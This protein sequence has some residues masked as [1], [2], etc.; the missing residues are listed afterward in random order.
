MKTIYSLLAGLLICATTSAQNAPVWASP[1]TGGVVNN[2][3]LEVRLDEGVAKERFGPDYA[4]T[5]A[6]P[7]V[8]PA[9]NL[10]P[11]YLTQSHF[12]SLQEYEDRVYVV[13]GWA[14]Y[15]GPSLVRYAPFL[16]APGDLHVKTTGNDS[17][18]DGSEGA[19]Y[20]TIA[21]ALE[22]NVD[23]TTTHPIWVHE[24]TYAQDHSIVGSNGNTSSGQGRLRIIGVSFSSTVVVSAVPGDRVV[25]TSTAG[26][27]VIDFDATETNS[28]L[29]FRGFTLEPAPGTRY[30]YANNA[31]VDSLTISDCVM[32]DATQGESLRIRHLS[33][34][35]DNVKILRNLI[36]GTVGQ[37]ILLSGINGLNVLGNVIHTNGVDF[38]VRLNSNIV[39]DV[40]V[41]N[42]S[43]DVAIGIE[44][45]SGV[46]SAATYNIIG[47]TIDAA[48]H[49]IDLFG[50][51][52]TADLTLN[53]S[54][55]HIVAANEGITVVEYVDGGVVEFNHVRAGLAGGTGNTGLGLPS[56]SANTGPVSGLTVRYNDVQSQGGHATLFSSTS[57]GYVAHDNIASARDGGDHALVIKGVEHELTRWRLLSG[58]STALYL[59]GFQNGTIQGFDIDCDGAT[60]P[61]FAGV[62]T[63]QGNGVQD[64]EV[65]NNV[66]FKNNQIRATDSPAILLNSSTIGSAVS[67][68]SNVYDISGTATWGSVRDTSISS[69]EDLV[70]AWA[71]YGVSGNDSQSISE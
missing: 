21:K 41:S 66:T 37:D 17:T 34:T 27:G 38:G 31:V 12:D 54:R 16:P 5:L 39:G 32:A 20:L 7:T 9:V 52:A 57:S 71:G 23:N 28:S 26:N 69:L 59:K 18:G 4:L 10:A 35:S 51:T 11:L 3:A 65:V 50:G 42:N 6:H 46:A 45:E 64:A 30:V 60:G 62:A 13:E 48:S 15:R 47:N 36:T 1:S 55:N 19:P 68:N 56:D 44:Q 8:D 53:L 29:T 61:T 25:L 58:S 40:Y 70:S 2:P 33:D 24:G 49:G 14:V 43:M 63:K 67:W 22:H